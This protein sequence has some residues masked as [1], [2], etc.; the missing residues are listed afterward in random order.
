MTQELKEDILNYITNNITPTDKDDTQILEKIE[1]RIKQQYNELLPQRWQDLRITGIIKSSTNGNYILYGGYVIENGEYIES[2]S[3][4][5][6]LILDAYLNPIKSIYKFSSGTLLRPIQKMIQVEDGTFV[7]VDST[8]YARKEARS[9][10]QTNTKRFIMLNNISAKDTT[11]DYRAILRISYNIPYSNF[12]CIDMIKN[13]NSAHYVMAGAM[14]VPYGTNNHLDSVRVIELKVNVGGAN[15]WTETT[16]LENRAWI[17]GGFYGEFDNDDNLKWKI[18]MTYN[19]H[20]QITLYSWDGTNLKTI[21]NYSNTLEPYVDS[22]SMNNQVQFINRDEVYFVVN[23]QRWGASVQPRYIGLYKYDYRNAQVKEIFYKYIGDYDY[24]TS[25]EGIFITSLNGNLYINYNDNYNYTNKTANYSYQRLVN[26]IWSPILLYE[27]V[28]YSMERELSFTDNTYNL[29]SNIEINSNL[30]LS[31]WNFIVTKEIYNNTNYNGL[32][33]TDYNSMIA[34]TGI[35]YGEDGILFARDIYNN[36]MVENTTTSTLQVPNTL[37]NDINITQKK[38]LGE[39]NTVLINDTRTITKNIYET[40]YI[41]FIRSIAVKDE[42]TNTYYPTTATYV[43]QNINT[44]T[45]QNCEMSFVGK[46]RINYQDNAIM[47]TL[48]WTYNVDH[49]E[50]SFVIDTHNEIPTSVDFMSND[51]TTIYI[52]KNLTLESNKYYKINQKLRIE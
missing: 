51:E 8:I 2:D 17:Y 35:L 36:T 28:L 27:N 48:E 12:Y 37:L 16:A 26:D 20:Q 39:T 46:V 15:E 22:L 31:F 40:L 38:L 11:N 49:Y 21:L 7:A 43:N 13:P 10:I 34:D 30:N 19:N 18:I 6:I 41:N 44:G 1:Q 32:P 4:G 33:Y 9:R 5:L 24:N 50:T 52:T 3:R 14:Y 42:D 47:Q 25:R 23:N 45:K 29:I